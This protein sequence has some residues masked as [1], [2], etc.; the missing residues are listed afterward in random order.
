MHEFQKNNVLGSF[1]QKQLR[2]ITR[3]I[4]QRSWTSPQESDRIILQKIRRYF[5]QLSQ[6][7]NYLSTTNKIKFSYSYTQVGIF[8]SHGIKLSNNCNMHIYSWQRLLLKIPRL[9]A[10][11]K[12]LIQ[13]C[14][15]ID[16]TIARTNLSGTMLTIDLST[17][18]VFQET[19]CQMGLS[20]LCT[21][22][23]KLS[24]MPFSIL[25]PE[26]RSQTTHAYILARRKSKWG[27]HS[28]IQM[29]HQIQ[30]HLS[31]LFVAFSSLMSAAIVVVIAFWIMAIELVSSW[32]IST[33][34]L[35]HRIYHNESKSYA[36]G[37]HLS[38]SHWE[39]EG[40]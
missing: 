25:S 33:T 5:P 11:S 23:S 4:Q 40:S 29:Q 10:H 1:S 27:P 26:L 20:C 28:Q 34:C 15:S 14:K 16:K 8:T 30:Q 13:E 12:C 39:E 22:S 18:F 21:I 37:A 6:I 31:S 24:N 7:L 36:T 19:E 2:I 3:C 35:R 32:Q 17:C 9:L 38:S